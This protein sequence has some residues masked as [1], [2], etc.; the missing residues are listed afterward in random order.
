MAGIGQC[1]E[2]QQLD[3]SGEGVEDL[4]FL[5]DLESLHTLSLH[6]ATAGDLQGLLRAPALARVHVSESLES[7]TEAI[8]SARPDV[9]IVPVRSSD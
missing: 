6:L 7:A 8:R 9:R 1:A 2:L 3:L 4:D 5:E